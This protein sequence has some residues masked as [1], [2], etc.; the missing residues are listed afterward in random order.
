MKSLLDL[1]I[2]FVGLHY[3]STLVC[4]INLTISKNVASVATPWLTTSTRAAEAGS[5]AGLHSTHYTVLLSSHTWGI[6]VSLDSWR[7]GTDRCGAPPPF[8]N[9]FYVAIVTNSICKIKPFTVHKAIVNLLLVLKPIIIK[10][11]V[12]I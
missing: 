7:R 12:F 9:N 5:S 8:T 2:H 6:S 3:Q 11:F 1:S 4:V 10:R